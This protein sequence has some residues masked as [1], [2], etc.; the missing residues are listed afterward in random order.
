MWSP[1]AGLFILVLFIASAQGNATAHPVIASI[2]FAAC[3]LIW[4]TGLGLGIRALRRS[5]T[6]GRKG[7]WGR[8]LIG[9]T[10]NMLFLAWTIWAAVILGAEITQRRDKIVE[11]GAEKEAEAN[12][13]RALVNLGA[14][15]KSAQRLAENGKGEAALVGAVS[16]NVLQK[17]KA[18]L[19]KFY[20]AAKPVSKGHLLSM[21]EVE[22]P[23]EIE[24]RK[25][26]VRKSI[27]ATKALADFS[28]NFENDYREELVRRGVPLSSVVSGLQVVHT[29]MIAMNRWVERMGA[30]RLEWAQ[31]ELAASDLL[32]TNWGRWLYDGDVRKVVFQD[33]SQ[34]AEFNRLVREI[35]RTSQAMQALQQQMLRIQ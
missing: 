7:V 30:A 3:W 31:N 5:R 12:F 29:N 6:E 21:A 19:E 11:A 18:V 20:A 35:N 23:E 33:K 8:A 24:Q 26:L 1:F 16:T 25:D 27:V 10:L 22:Q 4:V 34:E 28:H 32:K 15:Q 14:M 13:S 9:M 2:I 17:Q